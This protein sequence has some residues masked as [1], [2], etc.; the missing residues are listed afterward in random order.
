[1]FIYHFNLFFYL[2]DLLKVHMGNFGEFGKQFSR[3]VN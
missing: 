2:K 3:Q 1:M